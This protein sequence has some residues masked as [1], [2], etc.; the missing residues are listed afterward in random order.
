M[1]D[2]EGTI[3]RDVSEEEKQQVVSRR[4][5]ALAGIEERL[6]QQ[7]QDQK[8]VT[9]EE[10]VLVNDPAKLKVRVKVDGKEEERLLSDV[11]AGYQKNE[12]ASERLRQASQKQRELETREKALLEQEQQIKLSSVE[13]SSS[14]DANLSD[15]DQLDAA[16]QSLV[17]GDTESAAKALREVIGKG[18]QET[19]PP[20]DK[21]QIVDAVKKDLEAGDTWTDF[22][23][24]NPEFCVE[25]DNQGQEI[26]TKERK[27]G[28]FLFVSKYGPQVESGQLSYREALDATA[29]EV[30]EIFT[31]SSTATPLVTSGREER[32]KRKETID[33]LPIA[34]GARGAGPTVE[35]EETTS[36]IIQE[37]R[38]GRGLP[39]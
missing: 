35:K 31:P 25:F 21:Q 23:Q 28:D 39:V 5:I 29:K 37:M 38:K 11:V 34:A 33:N 12:V 6:E 3:Q 14:G 27:Y 10:V 17:N 18:R 26:V 32:Q 7:E 30:R 15:D 20:V 8:P 24:N 2:F 1:A 22:L 16:L 36:S 19:T 4:D 9:T 13:P